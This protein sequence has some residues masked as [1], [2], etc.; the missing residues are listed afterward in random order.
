MLKINK[1]ELKDGKFTGLF[2]HQGKMTVEIKDTCMTPKQAGEIFALIKVFRKD[3][4]KIL[5]VKA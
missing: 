3:M 4:R 5:R 2:Y 1:V